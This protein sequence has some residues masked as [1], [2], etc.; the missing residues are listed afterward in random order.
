[1]VPERPVFKSNRMGGCQAVLGLGPAQLPTF[2][3]PPVT[4]ASMS[5]LPYAR[6]NASNGSYTVSAELI[7]GSRKTLVHI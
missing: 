4:F 7:L 2:A 3:G 1:M 5:T 6:R